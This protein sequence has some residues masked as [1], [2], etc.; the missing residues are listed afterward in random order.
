[1]SDISSD[2]KECAST[3]LAPRDG[4][5]WELPSSLTRELDTF[6]RAV[7]TPKTSHYIRL[8]LEN[9]IDAQTFV[10]RV[11]AI[12]NSLPP[13][14]L[15]IKLESHIGY[16]KARQT[17]KTDLTSAK[18]TINSSVFIAATKPVSQQS[19]NNSLMRLQGALLTAQHAYR[20]QSLDSDVLHTTR[21]GVLRT[22]L[23]S[24]IDAVVSGEKPDPFDPVDLA[25]STSSYHVENRVCADGMI[26]QKLGDTAHV[27]ECAHIK[28]PLCHFRLGVYAEETCANDEH[29]SL[30]SHVEMSHSRSQCPKG[31]RCCYRDN[32]SH[33]KVYW[34]PP[35]KIPRC[36]F[37]G[38]NRGIDFFNNHKS[39]I[40]SISA[41]L[42][43]RFN[44]R[45]S[46]ESNL[47]ISDHLSRLT[48]RLRPMH[49]CTIEKL[50]SMLRSGRVMSAAQMNAMDSPDAI[51]AQIKAHPE[52]SRSI[53]RVTANAARSV[54]ICPS[55]ADLA[56]AIDGFMETFVACAFMSGKTTLVGPGSDPFSFFAFFEKSTSVP[57]V[58]KA[59]E[60]SD[61]DSSRPSKGMQIVDQ[62]LLR[63]RELATRFFLSEDDVRHLEEIC[64]SHIVGGVTMKNAPAGRRYAKDRVLGT[65]NSVFSIIGPNTGGYYGD[66]VLVFNQSVM[67]HPDFSGIYLHL[68][69]LIVFFFRIS[70]C[71]I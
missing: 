16:W 56:L 61:E 27:A 20:K 17:Y 30:F 7:M 29:I 60:P 3:S 5:D 31:D 13:P 63:K 1:M 70:L 49:R 42:L 26:C 6:F 11:S 38:L 15:A 39:M 18:T 52:T 44:C 64:I 71:I 53:R 40:R 24:Y 48:R 55:S 14:N 68:L 43:Q 23:A 46:D 51:L 66:I 50:K 9:R 69:H 37:H 10:N 8:F 22:H 28:K 47:S 59:R 32:P 45:I 54:S 12:T 4:K 58:L 41:Y 36:D 2:L 34:H 33:L 25:F 65:D 57:S 35:E 19:R 21:K 67:H 62:L